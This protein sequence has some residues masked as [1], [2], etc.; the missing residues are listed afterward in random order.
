MNS[1][2]NLKILIPQ[3]CFN[4]TVNKICPC[5]PDIT[6]AYDHISESDFED[7]TQ[8]RVIDQYY[9]YASKVGQAQPDIVVEHISTG[10]V[11]MRHKTGVQDGK[12][13][14]DLRKKRNSVLREY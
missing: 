14:S 12:Q 11:N 6:L 4:I 8:T 2:F 13:I 9:S 1:M 3:S 7:D 5:D 10:E